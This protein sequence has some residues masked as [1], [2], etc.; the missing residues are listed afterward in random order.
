MIRIL[1]AAG[2]LITAT[3]AAASRNF[4]F[5]A[6][7][8]DR[9]NAQAL[10]H[11]KELWQGARRVFE[12]QSLT[13]VKIDACTDAFVAFSAAVVCSALHIRTLARLMPDSTLS[14]L[15]SAAIMFNQHFLTGTLHRNVKYFGQHCCL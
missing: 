9:A 11:L 14:L 3:S 2:V 10:R 12:P 15:S 13:Q 6:A 1:F 4:D 7:E 5:L 8:T